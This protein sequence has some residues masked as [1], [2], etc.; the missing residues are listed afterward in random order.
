MSEQ[1]LILTKVAECDN[2]HHECHCDDGLHADEYGI[3]T[4]DECK[5]EEDYE[6]EENC[7]LYTSD[8]A[9]DSLV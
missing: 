1:P 3:C 8:A 5:H 7:L 6:M 2:C 4:C 9:D